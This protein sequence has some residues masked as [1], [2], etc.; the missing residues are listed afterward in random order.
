[1]LDVFSAIVNSCVDKVLV[2]I[3]PDLNQLPFHFINAVDIGMA[4]TFL[5]SHLYLTV[6]RLEVH[7]ELTNP[8]E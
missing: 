1:M 2:K 7:S 6:N 3:T 8:A 4:N 5:H